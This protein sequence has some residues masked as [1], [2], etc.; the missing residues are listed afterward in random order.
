[1]GLLYLQRTNQTLGKSEFKFFFI[2]RKRVSFVVANNAQVF[3]FS[4]RKEASSERPSFRSSYGQNL[5]IRN[6]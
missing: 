6:C 2:A 5:L 3:R 4:Y 1:M